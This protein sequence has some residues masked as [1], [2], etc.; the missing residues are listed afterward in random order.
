MRA[1]SGFILLFATLA[2]A[3]LAPSVAN[4]AQHATG[5]VYRVQLLT[6]SQYKNTGSV[7]IKKANGQTVEKRFGKPYQCQPMTPAF[8]NALMF[9]LTHGNRTSMAYEGHCIVTLNFHPPGRR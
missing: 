6:Q 9:A 2:A 3:S 4:A 8:I 7:T 5:K 1:S